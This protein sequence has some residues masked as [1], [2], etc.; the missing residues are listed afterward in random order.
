[1]KNV[2]CRTLP[3]LPFKEG[4]LSQFS[5]SPSPALSIH[6]LGSPGEREVYGGIKK[7][8][9]KVKMRFLNARLLS[10]AADNKPKKG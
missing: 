8:T 7:M 2:D 4:L 10:T 1:M 6:N 5:S 3:D 9:M